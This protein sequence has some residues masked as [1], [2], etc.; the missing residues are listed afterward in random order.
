MLYPLS[1]ISRNGSD[2]CRH[3]W[4]PSFLR[5]RGPRQRSLA[6]EESVCIALKASNNAFLEFRAFVHAA[7]SSIIASTPTI[8]SQFELFA[9]LILSDESRI[10]I[11]NKLSTTISGLLPNSE[12]PHARHRSFLPGSLVQTRQL[13][14]RQPS[15][16]CAFT[17]ATAFAGAPAIRFYEWRIFIIEAFINR[18]IRPTG[19]K[20]SER[21]ER[22]RRDEGL[23]PRLALECPFA[24]YFMSKAFG[25]DVLPAYIIMKAYEDRISD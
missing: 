3:L 14:S 8:S 6:N 10:Q 23:S 4:R 12:S 16:S 9:E 11:G 5:R 17:S 13:V 7:V 25:L 21:S 15:P 19:A 22:L 1:G 18:A 20:P 2:T 24:D